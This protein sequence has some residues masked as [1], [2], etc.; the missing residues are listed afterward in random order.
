[1]QP[2]LCMSMEGWRPEATAPE[3]SSN[4]RNERIYTSIQMQTKKSV[5]Y[6]KNYT[7]SS[8]PWFASTWEYNSHA[9]AQETWQRHTL[10]SRN[11]FFSFLFS[12]FDLCAIL[13]P[14]CPDAT[15]GTW[16]T[17]QGISNRPNCFKRKRWRF[18]TGSLKVRKSGNSSMPIP[19]FVAGVRR[20]VKTDRLSSDATKVNWKLKLRVKTPKVNRRKLRKKIPIKHSVMSWAQSYIICEVL[21]AMIRCIGHAIQQFQS[22]LVQYM[23]IVYRKAAT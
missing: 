23:A 3:R 22:V 17:R 11:G 2:T 15:K 19:G 20:T 6:V 10:G 18:G 14:A 7:N 13:C 12:A 21:H 16:Q 8:L 5:H 9:D 4:D 1:M